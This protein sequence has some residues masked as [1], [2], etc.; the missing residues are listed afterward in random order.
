MKTRTNPSTEMLDR[1][2]GRIAYD[3]VG[4]GPLVVCVPGMGDIRQVYRFLRNDLV[5]AGYRVATMDLRGHGASDTTFDRFDDQ[6]T[7]ADVLSLVDHLGGPAVLIGNSMS[8]G[9]AVVA[10]ATAPDAVAGLVLIGPFARNVPVGRLKTLVLR[11]GLLR[12]WGPRV[13]TSYYAKLYPGSQPDDLAEH[14]DAI[15][16]AQRRPGAW[17]AFVA[18]TRTTRDEADASLGAVRAPALVVMGTADPDFPDPSAEARLIAGRLDGEVFLAEGAGHYPQ[19]EQ[20]DSVSPVIR[21][22]VDQAF[23]DA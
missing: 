11:L 18:T 2:D 20:P 23:A 7:A 8:A 14:I 5:D 15:A 21:S 16:A 17:D 3:V 1:P 13:W 12:P 10:A 19:T 9:V 6:A 4:S 22:F